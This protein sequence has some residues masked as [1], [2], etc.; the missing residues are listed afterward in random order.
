MYRFPYK[1]VCEASRFNCLD[2]ETKAMGWEEDL[3]LFVF[4]VLWII[5]FAVHFLTIMSFLAG[6]FRF[7]QADQ[8]ILN[9]D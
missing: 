5:V 4:I 6:V 7:L 8:N 9:M 3:E 1:K 2:V